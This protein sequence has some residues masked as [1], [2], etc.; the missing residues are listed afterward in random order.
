MNK[1]IVSGSVAYD[2]IMY[3]DTNLKEHF[4]EKDIWNINVSYVVSSLKEERWWT[5]LNISYN[6]ALLWAE[7]ILLSSVW[8][9]FVFSDFV[10]K[11]V[12]LD[13]INVSKNKLTPR[14][15]I[16]ND[17]SNNQLTAF[18]PWS[19]EDSCDILQLKD[20]NVKYSIVSANNISCMRDHLRV[21]SERWIKTFFDPG[22]QITQMTKDDLN[23]C[24]KYSNYIILN[25]YEYEVIKKISERTDQEM[26]EMFDQ[27]ILTYWIKWSKIFDKHYNIIE[28]HWVEN[29]N[30]VDQTWAWDAYRAW[31]LKGLND[32]YD[33][34]TS[35]RMWAVLSSLST[36]EFWAQNHFINWE[37][38][39]ILYEQTF[40]DSL[41]SKAK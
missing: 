19:M 25:E 41:K 5:G 7:P 1:I 4:V 38:F 32:W 40:W 35:A 26:I 16:T 15:Y 8:N 22:Q 12:N 18:Y 28:I 20:E 11:N 29:P 2:N 34:E 31:I 33:W 37:D 39:S 30:F 24:F 27:M 36:S 9:D 17:G 21:L 13:Y 3:S 6:I 10:K 14:S 23:Y